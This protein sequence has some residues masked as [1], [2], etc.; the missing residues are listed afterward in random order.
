MCMIANLKTKIIQ[1]QA[2]IIEKI[3]WDSRPI[4]VFVSLTGGERVLNSI[5]AIKSSQHF[6]VNENNTLHKILVS[7]HFSMIVV[8]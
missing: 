2:T 1:V 3:S 8:L 4:L 6:F 7:N 5:T